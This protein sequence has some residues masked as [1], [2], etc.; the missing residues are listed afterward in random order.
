[1]SFEFY[2]QVGYNYVWNL[3]S[4]KHDNAGDGAILAPRHMEKNKVEKLP[5]VHRTQAIFDPQFFAP[6]NPKG[7]LASYEFFPNAVAD[8]FKTDAYDGD[9]AAECA[10]RCVKFQITNGFRYLV[11][12]S[13]YIP[14][15]PRNF[16][17]TQERVFVH[18]FLTAARAQ[19][20]SSRIL[21]QV[22]LN[23]LML[24]DG[25]Y[26]A[27]LLNWITGIEGIDGVYLIVEHSGSY[28]QIKDAD[29]LYQHLC[30]IRA[31]RQ[32]DLEVVLGYL[33]TEAVVLSL[34]GPTIM[35]T[36]A[37]ENT[38]AFRIRTFQDEKVQHGPNP[39]L[40]VSSCLQWID[41]SYHNAIIRR[42]PGGLDLFD[43]NQ[44]RALMFEPTYEW[45]FNKPELYKHYFL[46]FCRQL[47]TIA[48]AP[49]RDR[50]VLVK[51]MIQRAAGHFRAIEQAGVELDANS[52]GSHL[53]HWMTAANEFAQDQGWA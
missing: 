53:S 26:S 44:Y 47:R 42:T 28:K 24:K 18:P 12:P 10:D 20:R 5:V 19:K 50:Y 11:I 7:K 46:E 3:D 43:Q 27:D 45:F 22:V 52:D 6:A 9:Q 49:G 30:F 1:M 51:S 25:E 35:A 38:R 15:T 29:L 48:A 41:R 8:G 23:D 33:N 13:K 32:N 39:R 17:E 2:H 31:L 37:Y 40:Y 36:G 21:L 14:G 34:A 4:L 16:I